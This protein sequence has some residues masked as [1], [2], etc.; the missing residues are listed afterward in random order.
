MTPTLMDSCPLTHTLP[1]GSWQELSLTLPLDQDTSI[2]EAACQLMADLPAGSQLLRADVFA[3]PAGL[4]L[5][6]PTTWVCPLTAE[7]HELGGVYLQVAVGAAVT[8]IWLD[9]ARVGSVVETPEAVEFIGAGF[10]PADPTASAPQQ[11]RETFAR[12]EAALALAGMDFSQVVRTWLYLDDILAWYPEFNAVRTAFFTERGVFDGLVPASTGIGGPNPQGWA[13]MAGLLA[14]KST[15]AGVTAQVVPSPLQCSA[16]AYGSSFS[17]A[18]EVAMPDHRRLLISGT[19]SIAPEGHTVHL[20]DVEGQIA[21][22][23]EVVEALLGSRGMTWADTA[24]AIAYLRDPRDARHFTHYCQTHGLET[25][26]VLTV[27]NTICRGDLLF[28]L[29]LDA[30]QEERRLVPTT[31]Y[32][33]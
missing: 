26:P 9:G 5:P 24:R 16:L 25:L 2:I 17:R 15:C 19:A 12:M 28:E 29:E 30:V 22:T 6:C 14:V 4:A 8:P 23:M 18:V 20:D 33:V 3:P 7:V 27:H 11:A 21:R 32:M 31:G 10:G 13:M 1:R